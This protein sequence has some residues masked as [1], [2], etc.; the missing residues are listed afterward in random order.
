MILYRTPGP[1]GSGVGANLTPAQ[2]DSNFYDV[3]T[4]VQ[5]L[6]LHPSA[7]VQITSF[8]AA[9]NQL[10][11]HMSDGTVNG[12]VTL[13]VVRWFFR[14]PW[15]PATSYLVDDVVVGPDGAVYMVAVN[16]TSS[17]TT[18]D[19]NAN[20]GAGHNYYGLMLSVPAA[21]MPT[22]GGTGYVLTKA[23]T[24]DYDVLWGLPSA[25]AGGSAGQALVKNS[26]VDGDA[27]WRALAFADL[28]GMSLDAPPAAGDYLQWNAASGRWVN[29]PPPM[30]KLLTASSWAPVLGD[31]G[32]FMVLANDTANATVI[33]PS[34]A[35]VAFA[36]GTELTVHQDGTGLVTVAGDAGVTILKPASFSNVL[37]G[38]Y[39]T[40]T[41]KKTA[42]NE[43]RLFGLLAGA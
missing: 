38:K 37:L 36:V 27:S 34:D 17:A 28:G 40:A 10:Y 26:S 7:P 9:G 12:P 21:T 19:R 13:P 6:E 15:T 42:A 14:G 1:W 18:F 32:A 8:S 35:A 31:E 3:S 23:S 2:V 22:G 25:P 4:R 16:H 20:D 43:W 29:A 41:A 33:L 30:L 5:F 11:I 24:A 39:A